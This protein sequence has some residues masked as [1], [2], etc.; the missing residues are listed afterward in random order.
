MSETARTGFLIRGS[1]EK[2]EDDIF[3]G[4]HLHQIPL[5]T[6]LR[7]VFPC[8]IPMHIGAQFGNNS[9]IEMLE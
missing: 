1:K 8:F 6:G 9:G 5:W 3:Q 7:I 4:H 2:I